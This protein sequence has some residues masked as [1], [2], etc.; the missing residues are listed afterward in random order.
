MLILARKVDEKILIGENIEITIV[1]VQGDNVRIGI[2][3]PKDVK[4]LRSEVYEEVQKQ[5]KEAASVVKLQDEDVSLKLKEM[6][7]GQMNKK[8]TT[9]RIKTE[10][11]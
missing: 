1:S 3:A 10:K 9:V 5:N 7:N 4:I 6:L 8:G 11:K 2:N